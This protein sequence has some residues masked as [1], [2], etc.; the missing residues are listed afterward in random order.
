MGVVTTHDALPSHK[1]HD[2]DF[3][4]EPRFDSPKKIGKVLK[5][6]VDYLKAHCLDSQDLQKMQMAKV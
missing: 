2:D 5:V 3:A 6:K 4:Q 1:A